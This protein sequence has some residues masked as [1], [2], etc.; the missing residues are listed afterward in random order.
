MDGFRRACKSL[1]LLNQ[2]SF[3]VVWGLLS[4][5]VIL[6]CNP[7][8]SF[9]QYL[10][11]DAIR[12]QN[13][14]VAIQ[15]AEKKLNG[16]LSELSFNPQLHPAH[17]V[18]NTGKWDESALSRN[19]WT[20]GFFSGSLWNMY[21]ITGDEY[22]KESAKMW[23]ADLEGA[24]T[25]SYDHDTGFRIFNSFGNGYKLL[26]NR[27]YYQVILRG[28]S[29]LSKRFDPTI[30][31][32]KSWDWIGNFPV[33]ID[34]LMNL[35]LLFWSA[36]TT[37]NSTLYDQA[38]SHADLS[39]THHM[40][41]D[42]STYH[43]VDFANDG[44]VID[45]FTTQGC[46]SKAPGCG[47]RSVWARGQAWAVYGFTMIYRF[48]KEERFLDAAI[49]ASDY[50]IDNLPT[51]RV[52]IYDFFEPVPSVKSKDASAAAIVASGLFEL[53]SFTEN[54]HYFNTAVDILESLTSENYSTI[55]SDSNALLK[56]ST[57]HRGKGNLGTSYADYYYL[58]AMIRYM[59]HVQ[60]DLP[61]IEKEN[62]LFL[63]QNYP[64]PFNNSTTIYYTIEEEGRVKLS[65]YDY[66]GKRIQ[67]LV[68]QSRP[69]GNYF[70]EFNSS[71]LPSGV[72]FY[73]LRTNR[74]T[75]SKKMTILK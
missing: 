74:Q 12:F 9:S 31:A 15:H 57:L 16:T 48:T 8:E 21:K 36:E 23:T 49:K 58:E 3:R 20:S 40:R 63:D 53:Y 75:F 29:T 18:S 51:D 25:I 10:H 13:I 1:S 62:S 4:F 56:N 70:V 32:I 52:P 17:T 47:E 39:L 26:E 35:E 2:I 30:G 43:I 68:N 71:E 22:W 33:I 41:E 6:S 37:E 59:E 67:T 60:R 14:D 38:L 45:K 50:F 72:Y 69:S 73:V 24:A 19:E 28:A 64:N 11:Q 44:T 7:S 46:N 66:T 42:G 34:N 54:I 5:I 55:N 61:A 65:I 27:S